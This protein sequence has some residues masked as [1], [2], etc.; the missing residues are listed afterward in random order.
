MVEEY[1]QI[2]MCWSYYFKCCLEHD[3]LSIAKNLNLSKKEQEEILMK[4]KLQAEHQIHEKI[5]IPVC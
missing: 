5:N 4:I 3:T 2:G 1:K